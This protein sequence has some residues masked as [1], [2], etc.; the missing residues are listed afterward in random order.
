MQGVQTGTSCYGRVASVC[1][2]AFG[3]PPNVCPD[4]TIKRHDTKPPLK[5]AVEDCEGALDLT[6]EDLVVEVNMWAK[7]KLKSALT[8]D[9]TYFALADNI[10]FNQIMLGDIVIIEQVRS[11]EHL[12]V[13]GF[14]E[15]NKFVRVQRGYNGTQ[16][17]P[18]R[19]GQ[20]LKIFRV[21]GGVA[22][23]ELARQDIIKIDGTTESNVLV[24][25]RLVY[26]WTPESTCV[27]GCFWLEFKLL[28]MEAVVSAMTDVTPSFIPS[29]IPSDIPSL[30]PSYGCGL[31]VGV[32]WVRRFPAEAEGYLIK[33]IDSPTA[34]I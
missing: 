15:A 6:D 24:E 21:L 22:E 32:E 20:S 14:D 5:V 29:D 34:E 33:I 30:L 4:F 2:D 1:Q 10:G 26:E 17:S 9:S 31:G 27:P 12:L 28:K 11:P 3:C 25:S 13:T 18:W 19:K 16:I 23:V 8:V 7:G